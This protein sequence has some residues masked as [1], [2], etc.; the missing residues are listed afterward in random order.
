MVVVRKT[1]TFNSARAFLLTPPSQ[2][3]HTFHHR[4]IYSHFSMA[5]LIIVVGDFIMITSFTNVKT[6][7]TVYLVLLVTAPI[8]FLQRVAPS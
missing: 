6:S 4:N 3:S 1:S 2:C 5:I 7:L 8:F